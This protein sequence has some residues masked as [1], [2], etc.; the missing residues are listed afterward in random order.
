MR[1]AEESQCIL[2][3]AVSGTAAL[4]GAAWSLCRPGRGG[5]PLSDSCL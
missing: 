4:A 1:I 3:P 5:H 2:R